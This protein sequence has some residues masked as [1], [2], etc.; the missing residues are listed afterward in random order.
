MIHT[1]ILH[2]FALA[3]S[4]GALLPLLPGCGT[5]AGE[6]A[7][8]SA[9]AAAAPT[10][11]AEPVAPRR[12]VETRNPFGNTVASS[13][14]MADGDFELTGRYDQQPWLA[15]GSQ[16]Q[17]V[18]NFETGGRCK[19]GVRCLVLTP[20]Q[21]VI[22]WMATPRNGQITVALWARPEG[23]A[24]KDLVVQVL[25]V[26]AQRDGVAITAPEA[27]ESGVCHFEGTVPALAGGAPA[28]WLELADGAK[29]KR[30]VVDDVVAMP[31][32]PGV[33]SS[34]SLTAY[35]A[36]LPQRLPFVADWLRR[37]RRFGLPPVASP[38]APPPSK[39][40]RLV[41]R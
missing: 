29:S 15:F 13:N 27:D 18:L 37:H 21:A 17:S 9:P 35:R 32:E 31:A 19:S 2:R 30:M 16:G 22:G 24:C 3:T 33:A 40:Q 38:D 12:T 28:V 20:G 5:D 23:G 11:Q 41:H 36:K 8:V 4:L 39:K 10:P 7:R 25:D 14:M 34:R 26:D 6:P 1:S